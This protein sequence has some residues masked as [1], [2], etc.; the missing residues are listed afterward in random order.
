MTG[1]SY[2]EGK[3]S[4][5]WTSEEGRHNITKQNEHDLNMW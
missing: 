3:R 1:R 5:C 4:F 2:F